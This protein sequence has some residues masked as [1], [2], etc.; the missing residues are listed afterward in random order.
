MPCTYAVSGD[1]YTEMSYEGSMTYKYPATYHWD[2][3]GKQLAFE[4]WGEDLNPSRYP[5]YGLHTYSLANAEAPML[6]STETGFPTGAF[7]AA[8]GS[9]LSLVLDEDGTWSNSL[10]IAG[11][12]GVSGDLWAEMTHDSPVAPKVPATY[13]W[14][15]DGEELTFEPWSRDDNE[16]RVAT[17]ADHVYV[18]AAE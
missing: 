4:L 16:S 6:P 3:D 10:G 11:V 18:R 15:W 5:S 7:V 12:Y 2:W 17:Y 1:L 9:G 14:D 13:H 8:D